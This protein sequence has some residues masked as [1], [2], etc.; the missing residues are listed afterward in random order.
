MAPIDPNRMKGKT[1]KRVTA[2]RYTLYVLLAGCLLVHTPACE[3]LDS[4]AALERQIK[5]LGDEKTILEDQIKRQ[6][7]E[8]E[9]LRGQLKTLAG[10]EETIEIEKILD[11]QEI[12]L[13]RYTNLYD[14]DK[15]G[16]YETL[17][18][19]IQPVDGSGDVVK[20]AGAVDVERWDLNKPDGRLIGKWFVT[21]EELDKLW[22]ATIITI[23]YRLTFDIA[24]NIKDKPNE[25]VVKASF[26]DY[27]SGKVFEEQKIIKP[28]WE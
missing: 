7:A 5:T 12:R 3:N 1:T 16:Q 9:R 4:R 13:G 6:K 14:K 21:V 19:Y 10:I 22:F 26:T 18:V 11:L 20:A 8:N 25:L 28:R 2:I 24:G 15:D 17:I 23:N 27:L